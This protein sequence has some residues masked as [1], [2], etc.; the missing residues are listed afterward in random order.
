MLEFSFIIF[1][2]FTTIYIKT[3]IN[4]TIVKITVGLSVPN[5]SSEN[6]VMKG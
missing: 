3:F 1:I 4:I 2:K 5:Q 6:L